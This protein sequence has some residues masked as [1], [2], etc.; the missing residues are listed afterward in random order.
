MSNFRKG[1]ERM[2][3][4]QSENK[5]KGGAREGSKTGEDDWMGRDG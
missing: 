1:R 4:G 5:S 2:R 3:E